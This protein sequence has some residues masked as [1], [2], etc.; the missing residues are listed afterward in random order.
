MLKQAMIIKFKNLFIWWLF[1]SGM[2]LLGH[3]L[4]LYNRPVVET[5]AMIYGAFSCMMTYYLLVRL[6]LLRE[7]DYVEKPHD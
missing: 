1:W 3:V 7:G 2:N 5:I 6:G 4:G